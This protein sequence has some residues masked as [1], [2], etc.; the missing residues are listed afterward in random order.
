[1]R[2]RHRLVNARAGIS[3]EGLVRITA[4]GPR[5]QLYV[6]AATDRETLLSQFSFGKSGSVLE[7]PATG[8]ATANL[9]GW[10]LAQQAGLPSTRSISQG[11]Q[12]GRPSRLRLR[13]DRER[14]IPVAGEV[15]EPARGHVEL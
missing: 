3:H 10:Y 5:A 2:L 6:F 8:S 9:G 11:E 4:D 15:I 7:D 13:I 12:A 1:M 14:A